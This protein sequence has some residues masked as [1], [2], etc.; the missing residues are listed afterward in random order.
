MKEKRAAI[1]F[2]DRAYEL[3]FFGVGGLF[4]LRL[5]LLLFRLNALLFRLDVAFGFIPGGGLAGALQQPFCKVVVH[6]SLVASN[7]RKRGPK[8]LLL[9]VE[10]HLSNLR[11]HL[12]VRQILLAARVAG[13]KFEQMIAISCLDHTTALAHFESLDSRFELRVEFFKV[14][15]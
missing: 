5:F 2:M 11:T 14:S 7:L 4:R 1:E 6:L 12:G 10:N 15:E 9:L 8:H 13:E 3:L